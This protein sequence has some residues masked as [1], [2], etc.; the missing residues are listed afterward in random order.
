[1]RRLE[2]DPDTLKGRERAKDLDRSQGWTRSERDRGKIQTGCRVRPREHS[3][4]KESQEQRVFL[5][6][7]KLNSK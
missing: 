2:K 7:K 3:D 4:H 5:K 6:R 1:M